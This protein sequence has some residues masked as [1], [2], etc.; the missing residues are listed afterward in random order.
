MI[1]KSARNGLTNQQFAK[2]GLLQLGRGEHLIR[3]MKGGEARRIAPTEEVLALKPEL[4][5]KQ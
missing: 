4:S 5:L 2:Y 3:I 1:D